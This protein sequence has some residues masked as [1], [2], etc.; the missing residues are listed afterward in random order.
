MVASAL[1]TETTSRQQLG[2][3][4][5]LREYLYVDIDKV[6]G[7][8]SQIAEGVPESTTEIERKEKAAEVRISV[9]GGL[10]RKRIDEASTEKNLGDSLFIAQEAADADA[11]H[12]A[13]A[14]YQYEKDDDERG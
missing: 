9:L 10:G 5:F 6:R 7:I 1:L 8:L 13:L 14:Y 2:V 11:A 12:E 3:R 4:M